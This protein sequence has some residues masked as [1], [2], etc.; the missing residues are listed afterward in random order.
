MKIEQLMTKEVVGCQTEDSLDQ[1]AR[2]MWEKDCGFVPVTESSESRRVV[3]VV[4]DRDICMATYT[5]GQ[6]LSQIRVRDVMSSDVRA[7]KPSDDLE[8]AEATLREAQVHRLPVVDD[9]DQLLG[10]I[11]LADIARE[12]AREV[13]SMHTMVTTAEVGATLAG[14]RQPRIIAAAH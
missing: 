2:I 5:R 1:P 12:A 4:T 14:I 8:T 10:V 7:C 9:N 13:G 3:G 6:S 11:S